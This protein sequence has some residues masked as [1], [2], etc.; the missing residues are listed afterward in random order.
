MKVYLRFPLKITDSPYYKPL[1]EHAPKGIEYI[2]NI[3]EFGIRNK[4]KFKILKLAKSTLRK[5]LNLLGVNFVNA[6]SI[7]TD[8]EYDLVHACHCIPKTKKDWVMDIE[9]APFQ[10]FIGETKLNERDKRRLLKYLLKPNCKKIMPWTKTCADTIMEHLPEIK[11]KIE[12]VYPAIPIP[13]LKKKEHDGIN[14]FIC[15]TLFSL[16]RWRL[17]L[18]K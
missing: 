5:I 7:K 14:L 18:W 10:F 13:T 6:H 17:G 9:A 12:I 2:S 8:E 4:A 1:I 15:L 3:K 16:Q 11:D